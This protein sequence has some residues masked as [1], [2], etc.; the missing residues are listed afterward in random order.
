MTDEVA[1]LL[2]KA[3][4]GLGA[5]REHLG[6]GDFDF[7]ASRAYY[8][9][10]HAATALLR[11]RQMAFSRHTAVIAAFGREFVV[12]GLLA[13]EHHKTLIEAFELRQLADYSPGVAVGQTRARRLVDRAAAFVDDAET[14]I[15][16]AENP[17][18]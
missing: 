1:A 7:A 9:M 4:R 6:R 13:P 14:Y 17:S 16:S 3:R 10:F 8:A 15:R 11:V 18:S 2:D 12:T 5:A